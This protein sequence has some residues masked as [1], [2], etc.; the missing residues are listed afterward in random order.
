VD[1]TKVNGAPLSAAFATVNTAEYAT[2]TGRV[3][4]FNTAIQT[5]ATAQGWAYVDLNAALTTQAANIPA[6]PNFANPTALF[7]CPAAGCP[8]GTT[9]V[10]S[11]DG[12][13]PTKAGYRVLAVAFQTAINTKYS[14]TIAVP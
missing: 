9:T 7:A 1:S 8:T 13:H 14:T 11:L 6:L 10:F 12:V 3:T 2:I 4:A 5:L